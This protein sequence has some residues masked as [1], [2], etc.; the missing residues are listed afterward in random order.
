MAESSDKKNDE[1][2]A[3]FADDLDAMLNDAESS[4]ADQD[5]SIDDEDAIDRLLMDDVFNEDV[6][7]FSEDDAKSI[8]EDA[9]SNVMPKEVEADDDS[10]DFDVDDL[11]NSVAAAPEQQVDEFAEIDEFAEDEVINEVKADEVPEDDSDEFDVDDLIDSIV[12]EPEVEV[13]E[14]AEIDE[15]AED[16]SDEVITESQTEDA[17][18]EGDDFDVDDLLASASIDSNKAKRGVESEDDDFDVD[19]LLASASMDSG[20]A[21]QSVESEDDF[22]MADFDISSDDED[23]PESSV[24]NDLSGDVASEAPSQRVKDP[25]DYKE[26][27]VV[28]QT[29]S[30]NENTTKV[31]DELNAQINQLWEENE[32]LKQQI[33][34]VSNSTE[35]T[36]QITE[37]VDSLQKDLNKLRRQSKESGN[38]IPVVTY[39]VM[40]IAVLALLIGGGL[41]AVGY[42]AQSDVTVLTELV[43]TLEE[44]IET[45]TAKDV[46]KD[47]KKMDEKIALLTEGNE[48]LNTQL[49]DLNETVKKTSPIKVVVD[50]LVVQNEHA[51][52]AIE[53]L[54]AKVGTLE[55]RKLVSSAKRKAKKAIPK[56]TWV[57]NLVSFK[58]AWY[59]NRKATE[60]EK[61]GVPAKVSPVKVNGESWF[62][63]TVKGFKS[64]YE[65]AA[66]AVKVKKML[67]LTEVWVTKG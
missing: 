20:E 42:G 17:E 3:D 49:I 56:V 18:P 23:M 53:L 10:D 40:G 29:E 27:V 31:Y 59:A 55:Q 11:I 16:E 50:D 21:K 25:N 39:V 62:R 58:Q 6:D 26:R 36:D 15:F 52:K 64:K 60:Y 1:S 33:E 14:F 54:L 2:S 66:Y 61:K 9:T 5:D 45:L 41:G 34:E 24:E 19:D 7:E 65:A 12:A 57:V 44:E 32:R 22:L 38:K 46:A 47:V 63:L 37:N 13:D 4:M 48:R 28:Q 43:A 8:I 51:Q 35:K 67:N 30:A